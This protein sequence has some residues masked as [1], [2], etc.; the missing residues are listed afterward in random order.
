MNRLFIALLTA[1]LLFYY[2]LSALAQD[3]TAT[4]QLVLQSNAYFMHAIEIQQQAKLNALKGKADKTTGATERLLAMSYYNFPDVPGPPMDSSYYTYSSN[5][6]STFDFNS[7]TYILP[8]LSYFDL[9]QL[10]YPITP[11][12]IN[13]IGFY[14]YPD[15]NNAPGVLYD[16]AFEYNAVEGD[17]AMLSLM[18]YDANNNVIDF[19]LRYR[20]TQGYNISY[21]KI[22]NV[23]DANQNI[24]SSLALSWISDEW[25]TTA[26]RQL[27]YNDN[28]IIADTLSLF[29]G[30]G[31]VPQ[32]ASTYIYDSATNLTNIT[33]YKDSAGSWHGLMQFIITYYPDN[34]PKHDS[35]SGFVNGIWLP[36]ATD[37]LGYTPNVSYITYEKQM[38]YSTG[39][40]GLPLDSAEMLKHITNGLPD[41]VFFKKYHPSNGQI[42]AAS[43][44]IFTYDSS[45]NPLEAYIHY[46]NDNAY[47]TAPDFGYHYYYHLLNTA[48]NNLIKQQ[49][50]IVIY[51]NPAINKINIA[52]TGIRN[53][54]HIYITLVNALGQTILTENFPFISSVETISVADLSIGNYW[55]VI[56]DNNGN[57]LDAEQVVKE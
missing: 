47:D 50:N 16:S 53:G 15:N 49:M 17:T 43:K 24:V 33:E 30:G 8:S 46:Y 25:D 28:I 42:Q 44:T 41:T 45:G 19:D 20:Q 35:M 1:P 39:E 7:M 5:R 10:N 23:Y 13:S 27:T 4:Y 18:T 2:S 36:I 26:K 57:V 55:L 54:T 32:Y 6:G 22:I 51:P 37:S 21:D 3:E 34:M 12:N 56:Q 38:I 9:F 14:F 31:W 40:S 48:V 52:Q 11:I 29:S